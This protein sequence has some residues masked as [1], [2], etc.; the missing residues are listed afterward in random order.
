VAK[1]DSSSLYVVG[2]LDFEAGTLLA[3]VLIPFATFQDVAGPGWL[4][5]RLLRRNL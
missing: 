5:D 1:T 4:T 3:C 2:Y